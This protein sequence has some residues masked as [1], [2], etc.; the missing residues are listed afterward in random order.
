MSIP[1]LH[2]PDDDDTTGRRNE[3]SAMSPNPN[4]AGGDELAGKDTA[5]DVNG[6]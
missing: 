5:S 1:T 3:N 4:I 2:L 6:K